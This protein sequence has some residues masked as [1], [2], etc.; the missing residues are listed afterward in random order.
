MG[1]PACLHRI[2]SSVSK[3]KSVASTVEA[4]RVACG[5]NTFNPHW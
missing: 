3:K 2:I 1:M 5:D 4:M